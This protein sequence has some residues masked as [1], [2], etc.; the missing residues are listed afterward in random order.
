[1]NEIMNLGPEAIREVLTETTERGQVLRSCVSLRAFVT[2][3]ERDRIFVE[4][5]QL[6]KKDRLA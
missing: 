3:E 2:K 5:M 4:H 6:G 1:M